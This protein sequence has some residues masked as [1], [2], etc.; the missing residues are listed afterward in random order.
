MTPIHKTTQVPLSPQDAFDLFLEGLDTWWPKD[1]HATLGPDAKLVVEARKSGKITE[2]GPDGTENLWGRIIAWEPGKYLAFTWFPEDNE[3]DATV[4][5]VSF[6]RTDIGTRLEL[7]HGDSEV[8]G[9]AADA[10]STS[11]LI[12]WDLVLGSYCFA[13]K[14][15]LVT[16]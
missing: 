3:E 10:V 13:A 12:G 1:S 11:Y 5:A 8:L 9:D 7:T 15:K 4:V 14:P 2:V 16:A 6:H